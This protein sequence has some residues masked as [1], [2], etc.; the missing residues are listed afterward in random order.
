M[1]CHTPTLTSVAVE[2]AK[3]TVT[4]R[5][6]PEHR[7]KSARLRALPVINAADEAHM[8]NGNRKSNGHEEVELKA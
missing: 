1:L 5:L 6:S 4:A 7:G 3:G 2:V 8:S